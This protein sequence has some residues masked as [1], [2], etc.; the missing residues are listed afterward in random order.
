MTRLERPLRIGPDLLHAFRR[1]RVRLRVLFALV[2][3]RRMSVR[4]LAERAGVSCARAR[5]ALVGDGAE[6]RRRD[7]LVPLG[8]ARIVKGT[9]GPVIVITALGRR[10]ASELR[11]FRGSHVVG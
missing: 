4:H 8:L 2:R 5:G 1:S 9:L 11:A 3:G 10:V 7:A 6:Y